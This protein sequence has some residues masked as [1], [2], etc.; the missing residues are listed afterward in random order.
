MNSPPFS[1]DETQDHSKLWLRG[2]FPLSY[3]AKNDQLSSVWRNGYISTLL[4]KDIPN[5]GFSI[6]PEQ[7]RRFWLMLAHYHGGIFNGNEIGK[8]LGL[9]SHTI[10]RYLDILVGT[11]MIRVLYPWHENLKKRQVKSPKIYFRDSG[12]LHA[13][14]GI[15]NQTLLDQYPKIGS[16]WEGF[17]LEEI[18][19]HTHTQANECY[20]WATHANAELDL[21][22]LK[23]TKKVG[24]E[25]KYTDNPKITK[26]MQISLNDLKLDHI[27]LIFPGS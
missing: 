17:A 12:M 13:L 16:F 7:I 22:I 26:S 6:P 10:R 5:L 1:L 9:S 2:G 27:Y 19:N 24:F 20:F 14:L 11:F 8:S 25:F 23:N 21:L 18:I 3:L 4:E 15:N